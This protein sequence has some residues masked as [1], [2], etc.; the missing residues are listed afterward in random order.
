MQKLRWKTLNLFN[1]FKAMMKTFMKKI[2]LLFVCFFVFPLFAYSAT[3]CTDND[4]AEEGVIFK[5][6]FRKELRDG[7][8]WVREVP[9]D[10]RITDEA[11]EI[12][13]EPMRQD[14]VRNI[15]F[16]KLPKKEE[17]PFVVTVE[18]KAVQPYTNQY[19]QAGLYWMQDDKLRFKFV[20]EL[21]DGKLCVFPGNKLLETA[22]VVLRWRV[23]G[24]RIVAEYQPGATGEFLK[25]FEANLPEERNDE[26]DRI[27]LQCWHG[28]AD[29][30]SWTRFQK[31][32]ISEPEKE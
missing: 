18:V 11:L 7:W 27:A 1:H 9:K 13:M 28:P 20:L 2:S 31:F 5:D 16:R 4:C 15:L 6:P 25:A 23:D 3:D 29:T 30:E 32:T 19:Q 17:G 10:W 8:A 26:T 14:G 24:T 21:I 22:H 12:K